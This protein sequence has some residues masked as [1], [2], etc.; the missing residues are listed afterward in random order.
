MLCINSYVDDLTLTCPNVHLIVKK[1]LIITELQNT[2]HTS[3]ALIDLLHRADLRPIVNGDLHGRTKMAAITMLCINSY[4]DDLTLT[5]PNVHLIVKKPLIITELQNTGHTSSA[6]IDL[7][8]R[9]DLR[10]I[11]NGDLH[12]RTK[13]AAI[14][15]G[16]GN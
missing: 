16:N 4:V 9:A 3:S 15:G 7:L 2:S 11:V 5:C 1:P 6:L 13:M 8:H 14:K 10:P 12:G